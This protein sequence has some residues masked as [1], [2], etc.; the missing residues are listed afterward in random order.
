MVQDRDSGGQHLPALRSG[1]LHPDR[2][3][4]ARGEHDRQRVPSS[5][6]RSRGLTARPFCSETTTVYLQG[7]DV[8]GYVGVSYETAL[9]EFLHAATQTALYVGNRQV[10]V[11]TVYRDLSR[12]LFAVTEPSS[13]I[14][15]RRCGQGCP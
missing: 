14:S 2:R 10:A 6:I 3:A 11:G 8:T 12:D 1:D 7:T 13:P 5:L 15:T 9:H 4:T